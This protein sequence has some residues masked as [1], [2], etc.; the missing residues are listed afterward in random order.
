MKKFAP[1]SQTQ[2]GIYLDCTE[3]G[4]YN[5]HF[6]LM[7]DDDIDMNRLATAIEKATAAHPS[8]NLH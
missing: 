6:L 7:L 1:L 3:P 2:M 5:G 4:T 8:M